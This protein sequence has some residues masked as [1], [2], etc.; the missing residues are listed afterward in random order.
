MSLVT[1]PP[2]PP[3]YFGRE[4]RKVSLPSLVKEKSS[5]PISSCSYFLLFLLITSSPHPFFPQQLS[6]YSTYFPFLIDFKIYIY[7]FRLLWV[8]IV[9]HRLSIV[10]VSRGY[11]S[12]WCVGFS[13]QWH[14]LGTQ[15]LSVW[16]SVVACGLSSLVHG[17]WDLPRPE[18]EPVSPVLAGAFL[19]MGP[20][21]KSLFHLFFNPYFTSI[22]YFSIFL[23]F[24]C[25][26]EWLIASLI[27]RGEK[28]MTF[29]V[30]SG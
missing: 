1:K 19:T 3:L 8:F 23:P 20:A 12:L 13:S 14:L 10:A 27:S 6:I 7:L 29:W 26:S 2:S 11:D 5:L 30:I 15:A 21:G 25:R 4:K 18:I 24:L 16:A 17:I 28:T 9:M 22:S